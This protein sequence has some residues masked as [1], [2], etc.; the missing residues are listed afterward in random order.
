MENRSALIVDTRLTSADGHTER[1]AASA[2]IEPRADRPRAI[3]VGANK[4]YDAGDSVN[5]LK[6]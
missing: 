2:M 6:R 1:I 4:A 3:S 5:E